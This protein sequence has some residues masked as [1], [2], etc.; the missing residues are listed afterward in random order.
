M[1]LLLCEW[2]SCFWFKFRFVSG[3]AEKGSAL[4]SCPERWGLLSAAGTPASKVN[5]VVLDLEALA[6]NI[7]PRELVET[8]VLQVKDVAAPQT[9]KVMVLVQIGVE[10]RRRAGMASLGQQAKGDKCP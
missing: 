8:G 3:D 5:V 10:P 7:G 4:A 1:L 2:S 9:N 6:D